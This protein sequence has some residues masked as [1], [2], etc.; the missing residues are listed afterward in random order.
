MKTRYGFVSNSSSSSFV[1]IDPHNHDKIVINTQQLERIKSAIEDN[2]LI[3]KGKLAETTE[4]GWGPEIIR[5]IGSRMAFAYLQT[6]YSLHKEQRI[7]RLI[8]LENVICEQLQCTGVVWEISTNYNSPTGQW[9][10]IDH[11]SNAGEGENE[12][13]FDSPDILKRFIFGSKSKIV[14]DNDNH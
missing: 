1:V 6:E 9:A 4:F 11:Q 7:E 8:M 10:Y 3:F 2:V 13:I 14:L 12:E 5:D